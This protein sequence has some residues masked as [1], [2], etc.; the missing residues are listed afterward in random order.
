MQLYIKGKLIH[1]DVP[2]IKL[3]ILL[4]AASKITFPLI[5]NTPSIFKL[6]STF[7]VSYLWSKKKNII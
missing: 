3:G 4:K 2:N 6:E 5:V 7:F 1:G